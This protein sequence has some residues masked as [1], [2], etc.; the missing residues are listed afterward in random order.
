[1]KRFL[2]PTALLFIVILAFI[3]ITSGRFQSPQAWFIHTLMILPGI[4]IG[5]SFHEAA[6]A[7]SAYKLGD[8]TPKFQGRVTISPRS[9]ID[10]IGMVALFFIGFGW[11]VPVQINP[12][13]F[14]KRRRDEMIVALSGVTMNFIIAFLF[15]GLVKLLYTLSLPFLYTSFGSVTVD[16]LLYVVQI[17]LIL[18]VFNLMPVPPLDGFS[19]LTQ[20]FNLEKR[21]WYG[22]VYNKGMTILLILIVF[23]VL[24]RVIFP[25]VNFLYTFLYRL[26][27]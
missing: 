3:S 8:N 25:S 27:F 22:K 24:G 5:L 1:M 20:V 4:V 14:K 9:H 26:F 12:F 21:E 18:M 6:H 13:N 11:G 23:G 10:P 16:V 19:V 7:F 15:M 17:N 2:D